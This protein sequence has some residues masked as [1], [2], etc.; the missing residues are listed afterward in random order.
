MNKNDTFGGL[1]LIG[2]AG[3]YAY[4]AGN[5]SLTSSLGIGPGLFPL[6]LAAIL[7][8]LGVWITVRGYAG[9][10]ETAPESEREPVPYRGLAMI[11]AGPLLFG[12]LV[13]PLGVVPALFIAVF[14]SA[15]A[16]P[17][18]SIVGGLCSAAALT[19]FCA[20]LFRWGLDLPLQLF[21][22][23]LQFGG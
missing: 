19:V 9:M 16:N 20:V 4:A 7:A 1:A 23:W 22:P 6:A 21:G 10:G 14:V 18:M 3:F 2:F 5:L 11:A 8:L 13:V 17:S 12:A 15:L